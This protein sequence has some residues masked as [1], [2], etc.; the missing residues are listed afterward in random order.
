[1]VCHSASS[2]SNLHSHTFA[3]LRLFAAAPAK[4]VFGLM[5][6]DEHATSEADLSGSGYIVY[7]NGIRAVMNT[8]SERT[9]FGWTLEFIGEKGR[10][11]SRNAHAQFE[12]WSTHIQKRVV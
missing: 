12:L 7:E 6:S 2:L 1:M 10:I 4:W 5:V 9:K 11:V 8:Q 3:L